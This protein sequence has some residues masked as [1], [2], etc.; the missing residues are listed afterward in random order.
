VKQVEHSKMP[1]CKAGT[2]PLGAVVG[3]ILWL[4]TGSVAFISEGRAVGSK[5]GWDGFRVGVKVG[6]DGLKVGA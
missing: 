2:V 4:M 5:V 3:G 6:W 1:S